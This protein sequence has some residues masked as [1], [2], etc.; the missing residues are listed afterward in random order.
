MEKTATLN[1]RI[2]PQVKQ[3]AEQVLDELGIPMSVAVSMYLKQIA[4]HHGIPFPLRLPAPPAA[5][6][7]DKMTE[8]QLE[9][10]VAEGMAEY[11]TGKAVPVEKAFTKVPGVK[12]GK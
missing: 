4:L 5:V 11:H 6:N 7:L 12:N 2:S 1:L 3:A 9:Y 8:T 10:A